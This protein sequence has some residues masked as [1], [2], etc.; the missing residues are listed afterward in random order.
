MPNPTV[1]RR[2]IVAALCACGLAAFAHRATPALANETGTTP[3]ET[4]E[5]ESLH[6]DAGN[7]VLHAPYMRTGPL[8]GAAFFGIENV[9]NAD[10]RL[11]GAR[12]PIAT[13]AEL[14]THVIGDDGVARMRPIAGGIPLP[15]GQ[16]HMLRRGGDH[17]MFMGL[18]ETPGEGDMVELTLIFEK[19]GEVTVK[20][21]VDNARAPG[22]MHDHMNMKKPAAGQ[23]TQGN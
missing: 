18:T 2:A 9:G 3:A 13:R 12:S 21:P 5:M 17:V 1:S 8:G 23:S 22:M 7:F 16:M 6:V 4:E 19:A 11:I 15:A 10:D 14:H 20:I